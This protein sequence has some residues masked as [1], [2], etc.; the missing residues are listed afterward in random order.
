LILKLIPCRKAWIRH[1][2]TAI[3]TQYRGLAVSIVAMSTASLGA[4]A[5]GLSKQQ[6][7][8]MT[9]DMLRDP[10]FDMYAKRRKAK[11]SGMDN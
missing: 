1:L 11:H 7:I 9:N 4:E 2:Q 5:T 8:S 10:E 6:I 3:R